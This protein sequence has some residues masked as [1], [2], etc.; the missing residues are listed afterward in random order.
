MEYNGKP[1]KLGD[2]VDVDGQKRI[3]TRIERD[4][5]YSNPY[6]EDVAKIEMETVKVEESE[7]VEEPEVKETEKVEESEVVAK[8]RR[9]GKSK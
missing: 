5:F 6:T 3:V 8:P 4:T 9:R 1:I 7:V 2:V